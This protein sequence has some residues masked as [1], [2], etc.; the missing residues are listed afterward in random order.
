MRRVLWVAVGVA[1]LAGLWLGLPSWI[2]QRQAEAALRA[3][4]QPAGGLEVR[5]R[6]TAA[7]LAAG[8]ID[9]LEVAAREV[10]LGE[11]TAARLDARLVGAVLAPSPGGGLTVVGARGGTVSIEVSRE[12]L[13]R[14]LRTR[15]VGAPSVR[16]DETGVSASGQMRVGIVDASVEVRGQFYAASGTDLF[17]RVASLRVN[18]AEVPAPLATAALVLTTR[19]LVTLRDLPVR[20]AVERI[21][22]ADD[23][24]SLVAR[25]VEGA[26]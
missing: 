9:R 25:V 2:V 8:R 20:V 26:R 11:L 5:A 24:L 1:G 14:F 21:T 17:F 6:A 10:R 19:P 15:G 4:L 23:R 12:D 22:T 3:G 7:G 16:M 13:E 18:D